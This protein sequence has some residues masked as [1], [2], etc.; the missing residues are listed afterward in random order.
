MFTFSIID[1]L[2]NQV[3][4]LTRNCFVTYSEEIDF[5]LRQKIKWPRLEWI[6]WI[7]HALC[8]VEGQVEAVVMLSSEIAKEWRGAKVTTGILKRLSDPLF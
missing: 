5:P 4:N 6:G 3:I 2:V 1:C 7:G 8:K